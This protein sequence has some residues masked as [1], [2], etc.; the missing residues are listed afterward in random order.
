MEITG[1]KV[2]RLRR[3][4]TMAVRLRR[5][6]LCLLAVLAS[7]KPTGAPAGDFAAE[8]ERM[9][10]EQVVMRG[11]TDARVVAAMRKVPRDAFVPFLARRFSYLDRPLP[12]GF[13]QTISQ[14]FI[15]ALMTDKLQLKPTDRVLEIGTGSGYQAAI[16]GELAAEVYTIEIVEPLG[17]IAATTLR[18][19]GYKNVHVKI[20]DGYKG[21]PEHAPFDAVIVT[22]A[23]EKVPPPLVEQAREGGRIIIP[24]GKPSDQKLY[25][26]EKKDGQLRQE[27]ILPV[28][29]VPMTG[30]TQQ[31]KPVEAKPPK[32]PRR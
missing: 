32:T 3:F 18:Q 31:P 30:E 10:K 27:A 11:V 28:L 6:A 25:L 15:V 19:L 13:N 14:P 5:A 24:V 9:V 26:L 17:K 16:L 4:C 21:W 22:C 2:S 7:C 23:P 1:C 12:I 29:F 8:R 20:G